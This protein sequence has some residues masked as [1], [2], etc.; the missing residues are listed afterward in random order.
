M[1]NTSNDCSADEQ[2]E[3][4]FSYAMQIAQSL[5]LPMSMH[6][7]S[8]F[9]V[10]DIIAKADPNVKLSAKEI[11]AQLPANK[12]PEA[13]SMLD[14]LLRLLASHCIVGCSLVNDEEGGH[15]WRLYSLTS[16][17]KY[18]VPNE[19]GVS[20]AP[21]MNLDQDKVFLASWFVHL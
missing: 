12:N 18:F 19:D 13:S 14:R 6:A 11:A 15:P 7:V 9:Q 17:P 21:L 8:Q 4:S 20:L 1:G 3:E 10:F 16:V 2:D 5:S